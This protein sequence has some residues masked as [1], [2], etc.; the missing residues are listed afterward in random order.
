MK[1]IKV[2]DANGVESVKEVANNYVLQPNEELVDT[3]VIVPPVDT[4]V[5]PVTNQVL[6]YDFEDVPKTG[7][8]KD[9]LAYLKKCSN[10]TITTVKF[11]K[12]GVMASED[13]S[14]KQYAVSIDTPVKTYKGVDNNGVKEFVESTTQTIYLTSMDFERLVANSGYSDLSGGIAR[15]PLLANVLLK[16]ATISIVGIEY[17][18]GDVFSNPFAKSIKKPVEA[19]NPKIN[20]FAYASKLNDKIAGKVSDMILER[21][22]VELTNDFFA[23][24][25]VSSEAA[26]T[27]T[28]LVLS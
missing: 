28:E 19:I 7:A 5:P 13:G 11:V 3:T 10:A 4:T 24:S 25:R 20:Y 16:G 23:N 18:V 15:N 22:A 8:I 6:V 1:T 14:V 21:S 17:A 2:I 12:C 9:I 27:E 26:S